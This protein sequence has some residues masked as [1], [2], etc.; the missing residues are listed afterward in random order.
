MFDTHLSFP[1]GALIVSLAL[2]RIHPFGDARL[3]EQSSERPRAGVPAMEHSATP[4]DVRA[5]LTDKV[6]GLPFGADA[7]SGVWPAAPISWLM[8]RDIVQG[9]SGDGSLSMGYV[10]CRGTGCVPGEYR[11]AGEDPQHAADPVSGLHPQAEITD[12]DIQALTQWAQQGSAQ[13]G[14]FVERAA[15]E[16][17]ATRGGSCLRDGAPDA[18]PWSG[19]VRDRGSEESFGRTSG[20]VSGFGLLRGA[21]EGTYCVERHDAGEV[22]RRSG[23]AGSR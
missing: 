10:F 17:D 9:A 1:C 19:I 15:M 22:A 5:I 18:M 16:G 20:T 23:R 3:Y 13:D 21:Q 2:A 8:E 14:N 11:A 12:G 7:H 6:R 4:D